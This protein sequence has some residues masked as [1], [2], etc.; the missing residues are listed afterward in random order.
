M[1]GPRPCG[2][3]FTSLKK[4]Q[5]LPRHM[6]SS[7]MITTVKNIRGYRF[8]LLNLAVSVACL[9]WIVYCGFRAENIKTV[10]FMTTGLI[11]SFVSIMQQVLLITKRRAYTRVNPLHIALAS[12]Y[13]LAMAVCIFVPVTVTKE[14]S[15]LSEPDRTYALYL[16]M[17]YCL[18]LA[19]LLVLLVALYGRDDQLVQSLLH[20]YTE[21][22][23]GFSKSSGSIQMTAIPGSADTLKQVVIGDGNVS[24]KIV[25]EEDYENGMD[26]ERED[27]DDE[28]GIDLVRN[29]DDKNGEEVVRDEDDENFKDVVRELN[30]SDDE[31]DI[32]SSHKADGISPKP[33]MVLKTWP[34][35]DPFPV[36]A[37]YTFK[38]ESK[39]ELP[40]RKGDTLTVLDCRG[41]WWQAQKDDRVG[42][43][44]SNYVSVLLKARV[45]STFTASEDDQVSITKDQVIEVMER[46]DE[47]CLVRTVEGKIGAVRT[48]RLEFLS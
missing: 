17:G 5:V 4:Y 46:Y 35:A 29:E 12:V 36:R 15:S 27:T 16:L 7:L 3:F 11:V 6:N 33:S 20:P 42:F 37:L 44:P 22:I 45:T 10:W 13:F 18:H 21:I 30:G 14:F 39:S 24:A 19:P 9:G 23:D 38:T 2:Q 26:V 32:L 25:L 28:N 31:S 1:I 41:K 47:K 34:K 48:D 40:F 43:I 8:S